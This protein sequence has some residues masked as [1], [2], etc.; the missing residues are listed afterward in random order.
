MLD[1]I[2]K[3]FTMV[4]GC[5][6]IELELPMYVAKNCYHQGECSYDVENALNEPCVREQMDK[7]SDERLI[8]SLCE[9]WD[10]AEEIKNSDR[11]TNEIRAVWIACGNTAY[12]NE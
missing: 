9:V 12:S 11:H 6:I 3:V 10:D 1:N 8:E 2:E 4:D 7:I 5:G